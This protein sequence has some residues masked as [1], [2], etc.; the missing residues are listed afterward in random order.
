V[1]RRIVAIDPTPENGDR[2]AAGIQRTP[3]CLTVDTARHPTDDDEA[4]S[5]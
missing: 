4:R 2:R 5:G 1:S 3:V